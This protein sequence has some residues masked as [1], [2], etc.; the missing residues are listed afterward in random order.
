M[1]PTVIPTQHTAVIQHLETF[2]VG[3]IMVVGCIV[4]ILYWLYRRF[5]VK[6]PKPQ[7]PT[8]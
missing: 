1:T 3:G 5:G 2:A 4:A 6:K 8:M 7:E